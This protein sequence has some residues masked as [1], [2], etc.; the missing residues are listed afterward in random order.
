MLNPVLKAIIIEDEPKAAQLLELMLIAV[1]PNTVVV[2]I[3]YDLPSGV[4]SI[5]KLKPDIVFLDIEMPGYSGLRLLEFFDK[6]EVNFGIVFTTAF[7][8]Y[9]IKAFE[10]SAI[11]YLLKPLQEDKL[12]E[13]INKFRKRNAVSQTQQIAALKQN[14]QSTENRKIAIPVANGLE[15]IKLHDLVYFE[16]E[17]SYTKIHIRQQQALLVSKKLKYFEDLLGDDPM[18]IRCHRSY[19]VN[20]QSIKK[21]VKS[22]G[23]NLI[24]EDGRTLPISIEKVEEIVAALNKLSH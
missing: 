22:D 14:L 1:D 2:D 18:F 15:I 21:F 16:A 10:L 13:S 12:L 8:N 24:L 7:N 6:D 9:A 4:R 5:K 17:G 23:G 19:M 3:C 20:L 11:D